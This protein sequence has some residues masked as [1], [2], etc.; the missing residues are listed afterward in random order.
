MRRTLFI[1]L[2][3]VL[4]TGILVS[5]G[6]WQ[7]QRLQWK[8]A[9]LA[10]IDAQM[11]GEP[12]PLDAALDPKVIQFQ[13]VTVTGAFTGKAA[14]VL[15][16]APGLGAAYRIVEVFETGSRRILVDRGVVPAEDKDSVPLTPEPQTITGVL[17]FPEEIDSFTPAPD[18]DAN[19]WLARDTAQMSEHLG[20]DYVFVILTAS[21]NDAG[22]RPLPVDTSA[23]PNNHLQYAITWFSLAFLWSAMSLYFLWRTRPSAGS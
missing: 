11:A 5:L 2:V 21:E 18:L 19:I 10:Q 8:E 14:H 16:T 12:I 6:V 9:M 3:A 23:I 17:R 4:G 13:P 22:V 15:T 1:L 7:V 20:T